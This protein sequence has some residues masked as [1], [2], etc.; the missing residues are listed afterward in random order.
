VLQSEEEKQAR[1]CSLMLHAFASLSPWAASA[2]GVS[3]ACLTSAPVC[4]TRPFC[5]VSACLPDPSCHP[6][7]NAGRE[8]GCV[9]RQT[10]A[11]VGVGRTGA[12]VPPA[13]SV[14]Q[15]A[16]FPYR[17]RCRQGVGG[18]TPTLQ[19][20]AAGLGAGRLGSSCGSG[21]VCP[22]GGS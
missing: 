5:H 2:A 9:S 8:G 1:S 16:C 15:R 20:H 19:A 10:V 14:H 3:P 11:Q 21:T 17:R 18:G 13:A 7:L 22:R 4:H 12:V 6:L